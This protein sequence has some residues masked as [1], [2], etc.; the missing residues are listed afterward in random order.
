MLARQIGA[1]HLR[2]YLARRQVHIDALPAVLPF[3]IGEEAAEDLYVEITLA[4][5]V[6]VKAAVGQ[7]GAGH[8]LLEGDTVKSVAIEEAPRALHDFLSDFVAV[9]CRIRHSFLL[10]V[11]LR[12]AEVW[13]KQH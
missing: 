2:T 8:N 5:E 12:R 7:S 1:H 11:S 4:G 3:R 6:A 10:L 13:R 9:S